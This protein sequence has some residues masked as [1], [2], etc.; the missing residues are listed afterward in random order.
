MKYLFRIENEER[1]NKH[2]RMFILINIVGY[3]L[4][5]IPFFIAA[6]SAAI[7]GVKSVEFS[8]ASLIIFVA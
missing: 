3:S 2:K 7:F 6:N 8:F 4:V 1:T 5:I